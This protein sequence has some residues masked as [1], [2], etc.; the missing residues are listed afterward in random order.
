MQKS[1]LCSIKFPCVCDLEYH[2]DISP[3]LDLSWS[4]EEFAVSEGRVGQTVTIGIQGT[5]CKVAICPV[6][7]AVVRHRGHL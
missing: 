4:D 1:Y 6:D 3:D 5:A 7:H 2:R